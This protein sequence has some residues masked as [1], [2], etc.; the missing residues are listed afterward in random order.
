MKIL[1]LGKS[2]DWNGVIVTCPHCDAKLQLD[3]YDTPIRQPISKTGNRCYL[4]R[5]ENCGYDITLTEP[6][7]T[8]H[9]SKSSA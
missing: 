9:D 6:S 1:Q 5:C 4:I 8:S 7:Q 3:A 2:I